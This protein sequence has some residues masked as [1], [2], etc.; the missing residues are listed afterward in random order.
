MDRLIRI[1][2]EGGSVFPDSCHAVEGI[3]EVFN[4]SSVRKQN[5]MLPS[6]YVRH[7]HVPGALGTSSGLRRA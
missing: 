7:I 6:G 1:R 3:C 2:A 5:Y 4:L